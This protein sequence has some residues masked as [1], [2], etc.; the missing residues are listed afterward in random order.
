TDHTHR[1]DARLSPAVPVT[2]EREPPS[3]HGILFCCGVTRALMLLPLRG[4]AADEE[5]AETAAAVDPEE[6][7]HSR[8]L[9]LTILRAALEGQL[10]PGL[11]QGLETAEYL[12]P[13]AAR[14]L[15]L[16]LARN[17]RSELRRVSDIMCHG[18]L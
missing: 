18:Q 2:I 10:R 13:A 12:A 4:P 7:A 9:F 3:P 5:P 15:R 11:Q 6:R 1:R 17:Q 16:A 14:A 8:R